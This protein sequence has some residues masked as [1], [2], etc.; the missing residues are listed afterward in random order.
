MAISVTTDMNK[1][2]RKAGI[3]K[4][5]AF[6]LWIELDSLKQ[7]QDHLAEE[8]LVNPSTRKP[9]TKYAIRYAAY[10]YLLDHHEE[11]RPVL[12]EKG[13]E[14]NDDDWNIYLIHKAINTFLFSS[15]ERF[16][17]WIKKNDFE[18]YEYYYEDRIK[19][20][21]IRSIWE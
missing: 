12:E 13:F 4:D 1:R 8:G 7:V 5:K 14:G 6:Y 10:C 16:M 20:R 15:K 19:E 3:P 9:Y 2:G 17:K 21:A 11:L 18:R